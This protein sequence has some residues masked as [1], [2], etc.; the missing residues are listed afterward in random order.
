MNQISL[1]IVASF[2]IFMSGTAV[3]QS[4]CDRPDSVNIPDGAS[5]SLDQMIEAQNGVRGYVSSMEE[6]LECMDE[7]IEDADEETDADTVN[8]WINQYNSGV[9][10]MEATAQR[11]NEE[12]A[13]YQQANPSQ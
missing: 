8:N 12:R 9:D 5:A 10:E 1:A 13:A 11:F 6:Y 2:A 4:T 3:A 7:M